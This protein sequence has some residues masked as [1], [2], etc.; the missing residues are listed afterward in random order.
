M[1]AKQAGQQHVKFRTSLTRQRQNLLTFALK[2]AEEINFIFS[3]INGN[4]EV[5]N[6]LAIGRFIVSETKWGLQKYLKN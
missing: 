1:E 4:L 3:D 2:E 5:R 6:Q